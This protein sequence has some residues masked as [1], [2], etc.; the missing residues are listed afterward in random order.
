MTPGYCRYGPAQSGFGPLI[1]NR[2]LPES[3]MRSAFIV[4]AMA[5]LAFVGC[6]KGAQK[7]D[8]SSNV[9]PEP[10]ETKKEVSKAP[11]VDHVETAEGHMKDLLLALKRVHFGLDKDSLTDGGKQA[12]TEAA[13]K[14]ELLPKV[15][16]YVDGHTD[17]RG[18]TEYNMSLSERR[19]QAVVAYLKHLGI[20]EARLS[21]VSFGEESPVTSGH[22]SIDYATNRRV[23]FRIMRGDIQFVLEEGEL[24]DDNG[25]PMH[26]RNQAR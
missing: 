6:K 25:K 22:T 19:A 10:S 5:A 12:L 9:A 14:L 18:T 17:E 21:I 26:A 16:L 15:E 2:E 1:L 3:A 24:V 4:F 23:D 8:N 13:E 7:V 20:D 11:K